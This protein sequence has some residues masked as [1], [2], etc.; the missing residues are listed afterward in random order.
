MPV[1]IFMIQCDALVTV[2]LQRLSLAIVRRSIMHHGYILYCYST[3]GLFQHS[4]HVVSRIKKLLALTFFFPIARFH[5]Y[6]PPL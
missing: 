1:V 5:A 6:G 2:S 3:P 4:V